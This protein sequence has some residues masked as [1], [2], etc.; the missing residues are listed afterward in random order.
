MIT[1]SS[2]SVRNT[3]SDHTHAHLSQ[4]LHLKG[5]APVCFLKCLVSSSLRAKHHSQPSHEH[6]YGFS[7]AGSQQTH[8]QLY[9]LLSS[10]CTLRRSYFLHNIIIFLS[11]FFI[12]AICLSESYIQYIRKLLNMKQL[13]FIN[14]LFI[15]VYMQDEQCGNRVNAN[16][17]GNLCSYRV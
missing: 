3:V 17:C 12:I 1:Y 8:T 10:Y 11:L 16:K 4:W 13:Q 9:S 14:N 6:L 5:F 7:P 15:F 2:K